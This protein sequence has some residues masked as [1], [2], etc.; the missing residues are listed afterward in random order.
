MIVKKWLSVIGLAAMLNAPVFGSVNILDMLD[1]TNGDYVMR[2][3]LYGTQTA[4]DISFRTRGGKVMEV[5]VY[6]RH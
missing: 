2:F 4:E 5:R 3:P 1:R 6:P